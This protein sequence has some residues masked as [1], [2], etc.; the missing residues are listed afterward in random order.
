VPEKCP[1]APCACERRDARRH[2]RRTVRLAASRGSVMS[3]SAG[4]CLSIRA[5]T[6]PPSPATSDAKRRRPRSWFFGSSLRAARSSATGRSPAGRDARRTAPMP[7]ALA[8]IRRRHHAI[9]ARLAP[10]LT[11]PR[12]HPRRLPRPS[13]AA[14]GASR[15]PLAASPARGQGGPRVRRHHRAGTVSAGLT[16]RASSLGGVRVV[17]GP[18]GARARRQ[19]AVAPRASWSDKPSSAA[20][21]GDDAARDARR[22]ARVP[23]AARG[24]DWGAAPIPPMPP[25]PPPPVRGRARLG[26]DGTRRMVLSGARLG[27][28]RITKRM[29]RARPGAGA[30]K[31]PRFK[32]LLP[33]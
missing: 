14:L 30:R 27:E 19:I 31:L 2:E 17:A 10:A 16:A 3:H 9:D 13:N 21:P 8:R 29:G 32:R 23:D 28:F 18:A 24:S 1:P 20:P 15:A 33:G 4:A 22:A 5:G 25:M 11:A 12:P 6:P 26:R 7:R